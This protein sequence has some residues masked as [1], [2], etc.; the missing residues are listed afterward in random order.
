MELY[1]GEIWDAEVARPEQ[2]ARHCTT[3]TPRASLGETQTPPREAP[4]HKTKT[5][6]ERRVISVNL[7][8]LGDAIRNNTNPSAVTKHN[9]GNTY[10]SVVIWDK[11]EKDQYGNDCSLQINSTKDG[12]AAGEAKVYLGDGRIYGKTGATPAPAASQGISSAPQFAAPA[13]SEHLPF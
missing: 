3:P 2:K 12:V 7:T 8:K 13:P 6:S 11:D 9:N 1:G 5:M 4:R 10:V